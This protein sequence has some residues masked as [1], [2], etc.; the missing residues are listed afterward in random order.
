ME[1]QELKDIWQEYDKKLD[2]HVKLNMQMFK[3]INLDKTRSALEKFIK[4]PVFGLIIGLI[5][6]LSM[7]AFI[8]DH[9]SMPKYIIPAALIW[10][11]A[12]FQVIFS[13]YQLSVILPASD[14]GQ[15]NFDLPIT[16]IQKKLE[17]LKIYRVRYLTVTRFSYPLL[18]I[19]VLIVGLKAIFNFDFYLH[20]D[21]KWILAQIFLGLVF[22]AFGIW[23]SK[24]VADKN[25]ASPFLNKLINNIAVNDITGKNLN[26]AMTFLRDIED[27]EKE[28]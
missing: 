15:I 6:Q 27:F 23:L 18:W 9:F 19:P 2:K 22:I 25:S 12:L 20:F 21:D 28:Q 26:S 8:Y 24:K 16:E 4:T 1:L 14:G 10:L 13:G 17:K 7:G 5:V 11:F 3:K